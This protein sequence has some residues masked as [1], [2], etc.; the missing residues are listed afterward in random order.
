[1]AD[2]L[3]SKGDRLVHSGKPEWGLGH[4]LLAEPNIHEG[5]Q[6][7]RLTI[8]FE[9]AGMK[10]ISTAFADLRPSDGASSVAQERPDTTDPLAMASDAASVAEVMMR[11]PEAMTDPFTPLRKRFAASLDGYRFGEGPSA[12]LDWAAIQTGMKDPLSR[13]N[14]HEL[15]SWF[16]KFRIE[17]D[18]HVKKLAR[19]LRKSEPAAIE[20]FFEKASPSAKVAIKKADFGR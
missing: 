4:V 20:Q 6:C 19:D 11:L 3:W 2:E 10:T 5:K 9:R 14:R 1:M 17:L 15:E 8:R 7:Q 18:Q 16:A 13:F 12:L